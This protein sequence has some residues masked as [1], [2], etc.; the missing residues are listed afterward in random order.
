MPFT[1]PVFLDLQA[2]RVLVVGGGRVALRKVD[3]LLGAGAAVTVVAPERDPE[4]D[5][6]GVE[7]LPRRY[8][9]GDV[10]GFR[11]VITATDDP[12]VNAAVA[13]DASAA[14]IW[15]NSADDPQNCSFILPAIT[16]QGDVVVAVSTGGSSPALASHLR[17]E[18]ADTVLHPSLA[19]AARDLAEQRQQIKSDGGSTEDLDWSD[20]VKA[21]I[22][23]ARAR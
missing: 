23:N 7:I 13:A 20:R 9:T 5:R 2:V 11:L 18:I 14:G 3:G 10:G 8:R 22:R 16:R 6:L 4:F 1:Y 19:A 17:R 21:A 15:V 12:E